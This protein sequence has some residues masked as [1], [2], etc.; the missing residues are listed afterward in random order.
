[1]NKSVFASEILYII[2]TPLKL[3]VISSDKR[4]GFW[5]KIFDWKQDFQIM[6]NSFYNS[7]KNFNKRK[8]SLFLS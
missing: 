6:R 2:K 5:K 3:T 4:L 8:Y 1:M 7:K